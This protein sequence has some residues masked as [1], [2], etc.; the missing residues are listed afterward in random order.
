MFYSPSVP[1]LIMEFLMERRLLWL[2]LVSWDI[3]FLQSTCAFHFRILPKRKRV[4][5]CRGRRRKVRKIK[6]LTILRLQNRYGGQIGCNPGNLIEI[7]IINNVSSKSTCKESFRI[8]LF[9]AR[10]VW[11]G[12][13]TNWNKGICHR[14]G[15]CIFFLTETWLRPFDEEIKC[16]DLTPLDYTINS[17]ARNSKGG[18]IAVLAKNSVAHQITYTSKFTFN[19]ASFELVYATLVLHDQQ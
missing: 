18:G 8:G 11:Y 6:V 7:N 1:F 13:E 5:K 10:S 19:H 2:F 9:N 12:W 3:A 16:A 17:F 15:S 14:S 4:R